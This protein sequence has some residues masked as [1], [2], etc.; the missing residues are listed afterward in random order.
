MVEV[1]P[2]LS[3][4]ETQLRTAVRAHTA[5]WRS[6]AAAAD[7]LDANAATARAALFEGAASLG[8][9]RARS[10]EAVDGLALDA[11]ERLVLLEALA[12]IDAGLAVSLA[13][14]WSAAALL[15]VLAPASLFA[16]WV[17]PVLADDTGTMSLA[18]AATEPDHGSEV[19]SLTFDATLSTRLG[20]DQRLR[21]SKWMMTNG[22]HATTYLV[23]AQRGPERV[24]VIVPSSAGGVATTPIVKRGL[25]TTPHATL[26]L[27]DVQVTAEQVIALPKPA[28]A[29]RI[30]A[31][32]RAVAAEALSMAVVAI[33]LGNAALEASRDWVAQRRQSGRLLRDEP[34]VGLRLLEAQGALDVS[35]GAAWHA[36]ELER[37]AALTLPFATAVRADA[38]DAA[39][40]ACVTATELV[41]S[42]AVEEAHLLSKLSRDLEVLAVA[43]GSSDFWRQQVLS[44]SR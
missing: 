36:A 18:A 11:R 38:L 22:G 6:L 20:D 31:T 15:E 23:L 28:P 5:E 40:A 26:L 3:E 2:L 14:T 41:G 32:S 43:L 9:Q 12:F 21:G 27:D 4:R 17:A 33:G 13:A 42:A 10:S 8:L 29:E 1:E 7:R 24:T 35:R 30:E 19:H 44:S 25:R 34:L 37:R 39:R 16:R